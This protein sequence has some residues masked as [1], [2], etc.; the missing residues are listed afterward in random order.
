MAYCGQG[1]ERKAAS[2]L[3]I[4][5]GWMNGDDSCCGV[6]YLL[7]KEYTWHEHIGIRD[8]TDSVLIT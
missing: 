4:E 3:P 5:F 1:K 6:I 8:N 2:H 7:P